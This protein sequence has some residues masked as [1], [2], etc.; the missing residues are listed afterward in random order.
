M[1]MTNIYY[2]FTD[3]VE[4]SSYGKM[5]A[6]L[7]MNIMRDHGVDKIDFELWSLAI[8]I[9]NGCSMCISSHE[10]QLINHGVSKE[11]IQLIAKIAATTH[12]LARTH[13]TIS[14]NN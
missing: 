3:L 1:A 5:P 14:S 6:G 8:S 11:T 12:A 10:K 13:E 4:D 7:R 2:R 9:I